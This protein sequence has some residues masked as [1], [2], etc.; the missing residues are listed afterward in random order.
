MH[1]R[2]RD[3]IRTRIFPPELTC[4]GW[5]TNDNAFFSRTYMALPIRQH[6][7]LYAVFTVVDVE[8]PSP[9]RTSTQNHVHDQELKPTKN[10]NSNDTRRLLQI[11]R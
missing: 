7:C 9:Q 5:G 1:Y 3:Q 11:P 6:L 8:I 4:V 2:K 10:G